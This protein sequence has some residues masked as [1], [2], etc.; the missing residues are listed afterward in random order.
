MLETPNARTKVLFILP[1]FAGGG[2]ERVALTL[3]EHLD[4]RVFVPQLAVFDA[5][6]PLRDLPTPDVSLHDLGGRRLR[7]AL[8][9][10]V[11]LIWRERPAVVFA[12]QGYVNLALLAVRPLLPRGL[13]IALRESN[14]PS[15]QLPEGRCPRLVAWAYRTLYPR[16]DLLFCQHRQTERELRERFA[17]AAAKIASLPNPVPVAR[18]REAAATPQRFPGP[19]P[20][21]VA[22]GRLH[23]Q[24]G[25]DRLIGLFAQL[26]PSSHLAIYGEGSERAR[27][28][29]LLNELGLGERVTLAPF[30][31]SLPAAL[32]GAD[33]CLIP[34]RWEGL[35]N[36]A[37]ESLACG[38]PVIATPEAGGIAELAETAAPG[39]VT[40]A[41]LSEA[42]ACDFLDAMRR[43]TARRLTTPAASLLPDRYEVDKVSGQFNACLRCLT[44]A[45]ACP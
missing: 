20:R 18:L 19:G 27:L 17:V 13:R 11:R 7:T 14:T 8:P 37:L 22:A 33:A 12:T 23:R 31:K 21:F 32:A 4:R 26:P 1:N 45:A 16:A 9:A 25:F 41:A 43:C 29:A 30:T 35:P 3:L 38:T 28:A 2:A 42:G 44:D 15:Q 5:T 34:S 40:V 10:L 39:A 24:K 36:V 6:G